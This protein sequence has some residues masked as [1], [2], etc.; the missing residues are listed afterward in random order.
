M[1]KFLSL[2]FHAF[3]SCPL[4]FDLKS[5]FWNCSKIPV[6]SL[7]DINACLS[8]VSCLLSVLSFF[9]WSLNDL[10]FC[11]VAFRDENDQSWR[12]GVMVMPSNV[13]I[14]NLV[15]YPGLDMY[16]ACLLYFVYPSLA[17]CQPPCRPP[18]DPGRI[19]F[20]LSSINFELSSS[21]QLTTPKMRVRF[22]LQHSM[23][24]CTNTR[25]KDSRPPISNINQH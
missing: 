20:N 4:R 14:A 11:W 12:R 9:L 6:I 2:F 23:D 15:P 19:I 24:I 7:Y 10:I 3:R 22:L 8:F 5:I 25:E 21:K 13:D 18:S 17:L 16:S 1:L